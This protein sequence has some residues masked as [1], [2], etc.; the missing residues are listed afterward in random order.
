MSTHIRKP[1]HRLR[2]E[3]ELRSWTL[4]QAADALYQLCA[5]EP[6]MGSRGDINASMISR[7]ERGIHPPSQ[8]YQRKLSLL[9]GKSAEELEFLDPLPDQVTEPFPPSPPRLT[10][11]LS[12]IQQVPSATFSTMQAIDVLCADADTT[13]DQQLGAWLALSAQDL[14]PLF[15]AGW[16][17]EMVLEAL[18]IHLPGV[19]AMSQISRRTFGRHLLQLGAL[20][21]LRGV[22]LPTGKHISAEES[23]LLHQAL[24][25]SITA[26]WNLFH[27]AGNAQVLAVG[28]AELALLQQTHAFL[29]PQI[30]SIFYTGVYNLIGRAHHFQEQYEAALQAHM[31]AHVAALGAGDPWHVAQSLICQADTYQ[32]LGRHAE[33]IEC[34]QEALRTLGQVDEEH[35]RSRAHLLGCWADNA[36]TMGEYTLSE[37]KLAEAEAYLDQI[38]PKEEFDRTSWLQ[39]AGKRS[40]MAQDPKQAVAYLEEALAVSPSH[41]LVRRAGIL[42]PLA[43]AYARMRERDLS[44]QRAQ[45]ALPVLVA[46][47]A[48]M[49]NQQF[50]EYLSQDLYGLYP[51]DEQIHLLVTEAQ[52]QL[53]QL[54]PLIG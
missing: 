4:E 23:M 40:L 24:G 42:I 2:R 32:A 35:L 16:T 29:Y 36:M 18:H 22:P 33:A 25:E 38:S 10:S 53:P 6:R 17:P 27:T 1:N 47:N 7:W 48:P 28:Q 15:D 30:R 13:P 20:A 14:I 45:Q 11:V 44:L 9:Y 34:I 26:G 39:L 54:A 19:H 12:N 3:R 21:L 51:H 8:F 43:I 52:Q 41:W 49:T 5:K 50:A 31:S 46:M 37:H